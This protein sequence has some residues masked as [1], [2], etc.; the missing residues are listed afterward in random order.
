MCQIFNPK[1][2]DDGYEHETG[3]VIIETF[4]KRGIDVMEI[5]GVLLHGHGPFTWGKMLKV[6]L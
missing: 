2:I 1:E 6:P 5:P 3:K 4:K